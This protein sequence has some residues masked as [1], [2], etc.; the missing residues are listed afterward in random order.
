M[1]AAVKKSLMMRSTVYKDIKSDVLSTLT[2]LSESLKLDAKTL[3][4]SFDKFMTVSR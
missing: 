4:S 2:S 1:E 3:A